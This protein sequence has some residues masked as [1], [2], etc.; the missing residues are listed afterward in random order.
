MSLRSFHIVFVTLTT[1]LSLFLVVWSYKLAPLEAA[2]TA[3]IMGLVGVIGLI[4]GPV[5]GVY[6][7]RKAKKLTL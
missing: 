6:F 5:Y 2:G 7:Y 1:F 3:K 4:V